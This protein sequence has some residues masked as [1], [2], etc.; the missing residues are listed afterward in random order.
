MEAA[1]LDKFQLDYCYSTVEN[2]I[3]FIIE[4]KFKKK[5]MQ[6]LS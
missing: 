4:K 2:K 1:I 6:L 3:C 5:T